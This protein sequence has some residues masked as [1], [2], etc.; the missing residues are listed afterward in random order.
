MT[1]LFDDPK[2]FPHDAVEGLVAAHPE[3]LLRVHGG[4]V[5][6][7]RT[8]AGQPALVV[9]GGSGHYPAFA[10]WVGPGFAHGAPC[11]NIFSS[12]SS[13]QVYS[14]AKNAENGG[15]VILGFGHY[16]GDVLH[17]GVAAEKLRA[18]GIDVRIVAVSD[19]VASGAKG[20]HRDRRGIAGDLPVFKIAGAAIQAGADL[21]EAERLTWKANDATRSLGVA[22]D[23]C[24]L[25]GAEDALFHV[26]EGRMAIGLGIHGEPGIDEQPMPSAKE[27][28][29][30]LV[31]GVLAETPELDSERAAVVLNGLGT[32]K[33]EEMFV[34]WKHC[35]ELLAEAG[36]T[37]VRP[38]VGE[39][40]TSLDMAGLSLTVMRLDEELEQLWLAPADA[41]AFRRG[42]TVGGD[43]GEERDGVYTP[44]EDPIPEASED[45]RASA[46]RILAHL[47]AVEELLRD[48]EPELGRM[49]QVAGDGDHGQ[50][51]VLGATAARA[52]AERVVAADGGARTVLVQ[53]GAA[54]SAE[55]G[56]TS[57]A[58]WGAA[59]T[60]LGSAFSDDAAATGDQLLTG[61]VQAVEAIERLGGAT[62][63]DKT[64]VDAAVPF[65]EAIALSQAGGADA[66]GPAETA[67]TVVA[68]A[69]ARAVEAAEATAD[70]A[71]TMGRA[72]NHGDKS[73]G[74]PDPGA[75]SFS[76][77]VTLLGEKLAG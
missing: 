11:G 13:D 76:K 77:I 44:G 12:P 20:E 59:L 40:V 24:T 23:G 28:A 27:L 49:D 75:I 26:P 32:V 46:Q 73:V 62:P 53:A 64:M 5:R 50:G 8:P 57:G 60:S 56:G 45:S 63:G 68:T 54:W 52:A 16:A 10:G 39:H 19:D 35:A 3:G 22:F 33:Y 30:V 15:G 74:T 2:T 9:G 42:G 34:V 31:D 6:A 48:L 1:Y 66:D 36:L 70:I 21:A 58:L 7:R 69:A 61:L 51:M 29:K 17:F 4:V 43:L 67:A 18:E 14:V 37:V 25:P 38:E 72:R 55:A 71:A 41:P 65:R 47:G